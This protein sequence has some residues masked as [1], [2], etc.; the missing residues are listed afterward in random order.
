MIAFVVQLEDPRQ[1][2]DLTMCDEASVEQLHKRSPR[3][4]SGSALIDFGHLLE[5]LADA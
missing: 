2:L 1:F 3:L 4:V 5:D